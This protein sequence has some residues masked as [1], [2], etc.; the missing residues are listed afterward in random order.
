MIKLQNVY[1]YY[2]TNDIVTQALKNINLEL[3]KNEVVAIIGESG[4][5][6]TTLL[7]VICGVDN[8]DEGEMCLKGNETSYFS[9]EDMEYY[10]KKNVAFIYQSY[11]I[12]ESYTVLDNVIVP[13]ML[14]GLKYNEAKEEAIKIID[15]VGLLDRLNSKG[16]NLSGG[17]KQRCVIA[18]ALASKCEILAC[19]EPTGNLDS[20]TG[21]NIVKLIKEIAQDKLVLIVTHNY[22]QIEDITTRTIKISDGQII[23][24]YKKDVI[25]DQEKI[26]T[27]DLSANKCPKKNIFNFSFKNILSKINTT[28]F[29]FMVLTIL[30]VLVM[31]LL[32][33]NVTWS[34]NNKYNPVVGFNNTI[35]NRVIIFDDN[36]EKI[37]VD[38]FNNIDG[39]IFENP[40]YED[41]LLSFTIGDAKRLDDRL[42]L[43]IDGCF[44]QMMPEKMTHSYGQLPDESG[45]CYILLPED[46][47]GKYSDQM[48]KYIG[49][50]INFRDHEILLKLNLC[51]YGYSKEVSHLTFVAYDDVS[52]KLAKVS[53]P[54]IKAYTYFDEKYIEVGHRYSWDIDKPVVY[55]TGESKDIFDKIYFKFND[56]YID[57]LNS[58]EFDLV[59]YESNELSISV[60]IPFNYQMGDVFELAIYTN[61]PDKVIKQAKKLGYLAIQPGKAGV[62]EESNDNQ[63]A[64]IFMIISVIASLILV[65]VTY[66]ILSKIYVNKMKDYNIFRSLGYTKEDMKIMV[67]FEL[68]MI[69]FV[70]VILGIIML[71]TSSLFV[72][73]IGEILENNSLFIMLL[74]TLIMLLFALFISSKFNKKLFKFTVQKTFYREVL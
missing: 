43:G 6:K 66:I 16:A 60:M 51:G 70:S 46:K 17:E 65:F 23:E 42:D 1:K 12:I 22:E 38:D 19:D 29:S 24:D 50:K 3:H 53:T 25:N 27:L 44:S 40:F 61:N 47:Y 45:E 35:Y 41:V 13:L 73:F 58:N 68:L 37:N 10:R 36:H 64:V 57:E 49:Q 63:Y 9:I 7:N 67:H 31:F 59:Y 21:D 48:M 34:E 52:S 18:R 72:D 62:D 69:T 4:S 15:R 28:I 26:E 54:K 30:S 39:E 71:Y 5:G 14:D 8:Y 2:N 56:I 20:K 32:L 33:T 11:N 74:F 55:L